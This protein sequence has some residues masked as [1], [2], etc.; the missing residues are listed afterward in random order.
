MHF[1]W[2]K[3]SQIRWRC[4]SSL[5]PSVQLTIFQ[6]WLRYWLG[7]AQATSHYLKLW[8]LVD[9][10]IWH[11]CVTRPQWGVYCGHIV[12]VRQHKLTHNLIAI[13][14]PTGTLVILR[15]KR[16]C[17]CYLLPVK[18]MRMY[19]LQWYFYP[20]VM[21]SF[22]HTI[23]IYICYLIHYLPQRKGKW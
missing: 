11:I 9:W 10:H 20:E 12:P 6:H 1:S 17:Q 5:F 21:D 16:K 15:N 4:H 7:T 8:W 2:M 3:V 18:F 23:Y 14:H 13:L 22:Y 19:I